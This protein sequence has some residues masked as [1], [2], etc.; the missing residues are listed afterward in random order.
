MSYANEAYCENNIQNYYLLTFLGSVL[1]EAMIVESNVIAFADDT[2]E[3]SEAYVVYVYEDYVNIVEDAEM[4]D[5]NT[6]YQII[7]YCQFQGIEY[8]FN[9]WKDA[10]ELLK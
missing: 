1:G 5:I 10:K 8:K 3:Y 2:K 7:G 6:M 9:E 4:L